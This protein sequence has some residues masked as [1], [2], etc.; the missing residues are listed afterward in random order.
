MISAFLSSKVKI[1]FD[2]WYDEKLFILQILFMV[3]KKS[4]KQVEWYLVV[5]TIYSHAFNWGSNSLTTINDNNF[6]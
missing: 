3:N 4:I 2:V 1:F 5:D 6:H